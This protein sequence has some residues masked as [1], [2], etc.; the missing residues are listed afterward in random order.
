MVIRTHIRIVLTILLIVF[1]YL[2]FNLASSNEQK[3]CNLNILTS[4]LNIK[5]ENLKSLKDNLS[6][7]GPTL[8]EYYEDYD[9]RI[10]TTSMGAE[11]SFT[12]IKYWVLSKDDFVAEF[13]VTWFEDPQQNKTQGPYAK[14][15]FICD[16][17]LVEMK[18][19]HK[20]EPIK[21]PEDDIEMSI[22]IYKEIISRSRLLKNGKEK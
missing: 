18:N 4:L 19:S 9:L 13:K 15:F 2:P 6:A 12:E 21:Y 7:D 11:H 22:E 14:I 17:K 16:N 20:Y 1:G 10:I 5:I 3:I 8:T